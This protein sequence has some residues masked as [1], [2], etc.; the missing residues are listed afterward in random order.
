[1]NLPKCALVLRETLTISGNSAY[2]K[3]YTFSSPLLFIITGIKAVYTGTHMYVF[4][5]NKTDPSFPTIS[6]YFFPLSYAFSER[7][8]KPATTKIR[9]ARWSF[10]KLKMAGIFCTK[11]Y[12]GKKVWYLLV[13]TIT[14]HSICQHF[15]QNC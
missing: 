3:T 5:I 2:L 6:L 14:A 13:E 7:S 10:L 12:S 8:T 11:G 1:M 4:M 9:K 15:T